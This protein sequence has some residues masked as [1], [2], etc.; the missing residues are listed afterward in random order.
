MSL[1]VA[2]CLIKIFHTDSVKKYCIYIMY[3]FPAANVKLCVTCVILY[4]CSY[5]VKWEITTNRYIICSFR[6]YAGL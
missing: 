3:I 2:R 6:V 4:C 1:N 5:I